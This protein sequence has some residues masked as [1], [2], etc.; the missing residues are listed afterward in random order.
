MSKLYQEELSRLMQSQQRARLQGG[1]KPPPELPGLPGLFPGLAGGLFQRAQQ[2]DLQ[3]AMD[4]YQQEF[5]RLHQNALAAAFRAQQNGS[6]DEDT[7]SETPNPP[8]SP[9]TSSG[10]TKSPGARQESPIGKL[11]FLEI[12]FE[13]LVLSRPFSMFLGVFKAHCYLELFRAQFLMY[14]V[15][16]L[17]KTIRFSLKS[18]LSEQFHWPEMSQIKA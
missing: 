3:R 2:S 9:A 18:R 14:S 13:I 16:N 5:N 7:K 11:N 17:E 4:V 6:K 15:R 10:D 8:E 12:Y 1:D